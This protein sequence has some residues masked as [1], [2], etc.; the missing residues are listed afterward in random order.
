M[1][2]EQEVSDERSKLYQNII[3]QKKLLLDRI[4]EQD[5]VLLSLKS[6]MDETIVKHNMHQSTYL[7]NERTP[8][9]N[10]INKGFYYNVASDDQNNSINLARK[11]SVQSSINDNSMLHKGYTVPG[12]RLYH[13]GLKNYQHKQDMR[14]SMYDDLKSYRN[15][16]KML[17]YS[18]ELIHKKTH[19]KIEFQ[20]NRHCKN[21]YEITFVEIG[22]LF[23]DLGIFKIF[24]SEDF[25]TKQRVIEKFKSNPERARLEASFHDQI[26]LFMSN[27]S[28]GDSNKSVPRDLARII[29]GHFMILG[30]PNKQ[31]A[32]I[33]INK[34]VAYLV[35]AGHSQSIAEEV[36][37]NILERQKENPKNWDIEKLFSVW[38]SFMKDSNVSN[39]KSFVNPTLS[40]FIGSNNSKLNTTMQASMRDSTITR[41][42]SKLNRESVDARRSLEGS[43]HKYTPELNRRSV[44]IDKNRQ[45]S[46]FRDEDIS[47]KS[48][49]PINRYELL[50]EYH[51]Y[52]LDKKDRKKEEAEQDELKECTFKPALISQQMESIYPGES[53]CDGELL[54]PNVYKSG[55]KHKKSKNS[56][57]YQ[58]D[59]N[60]HM[61]EKS[62]LKKQQRELSNQQAMS[63]TDLK[64]AKEM[65]KC[66]FEP[67]LSKSQNY[68]KN[69][70]NARKT[71]N[72]VRGFEK[73]NARLKYA[74]EKKE[75]DTII[76]E[77]L[78][79]INLNKIKEEQ[80]DHFNN[81]NLNSISNDN[82][83]AV[84][85]NPI[86]L[87]VDVT[88]SK[89]KT[90]KISIRKYDEPEELAGRFTQIYNLSED[91]HSH[92][93]EMLREYKQQFL[94]RKNMLDIK[95]DTEEDIRESCD[96]E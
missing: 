85:E 91:V 53:L 28:N 31:G 21:E 74:Q 25:T 89:N 95:E 73:F 81:I 92:L 40:N 32:S 36:I 30:Y 61:Y 42:G 58:E 79:N 16:S 13:E 64:L 83:E 19:V 77:N 70:S 41:G 56:N 7:D 14:Q 76:Y 72:D 27:F 50:F 29:L 45:E 63:T 75:A 48:T 4:N 62:I 20:L 59:Y 96:A 17:P 84:E 23:C 94:V 57:L 12:E 38:K 87:T 44:L 60:V 11:G 67:D 69:L 65:S 35:H 82:T 46:Q 39:N 90:G 3:E 93:V 88:M 33:L 24:D 37:I 68:D 1:N 6:K 34:L 71:T 66:T 8:T 43:K 49:M 55:G 54:S 78:G 47:Q 15:E 10:S 80:E 9:N 26:W 5:D 86:I 51:R 2:F 18:D 22:A 52:L